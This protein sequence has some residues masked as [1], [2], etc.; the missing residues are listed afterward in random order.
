MC[1]KESPRSIRHCSNSK[2]SC[3]CRIWAVPRFKPALRWECGQPTTS[4]HSLAAIRP[5]IAS[6]DP[7]AH[8]EDALQRRLEVPHQGCLRLVGIAPY[9]GFENLDVLAQSA[10]RE[11]RGDPAIELDQDEIVLEA[12]GG[13]LDEGIAQAGH[14]LP[15][16]AT[17]ERFELRKIF[18]LES[19]ARN[20]FDQGFMV[21]E[22]PGDRLRIGALRIGAGRGSLDHGAELVGAAR[23]LEIGFQELDAGARV[24]G[25]DTLGLQYP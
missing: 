3:C 12:P 13:G 20:L 23:E 14:H 16:Q 15:M 22:Q 7:S 2:T 8:A 25:E 4:T 5:R 9:A 1:T 18:R 17:L 19:F 6:P 11:R 24:N 10:Q 21:L